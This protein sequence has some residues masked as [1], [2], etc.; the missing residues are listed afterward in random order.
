MSSI[1]FS[2]MYLW[3]EVSQVEHNMLSDGV[4]ADAVTPLCMA[5]ILTGG[6]D[7]SVAMLTKGESRYVLPFATFGLEL[8]YVPAHVDSH[9]SPVVRQ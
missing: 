9:A 5:E 1:S 8:R 2:L 7:R 3:N 4:G 6:R